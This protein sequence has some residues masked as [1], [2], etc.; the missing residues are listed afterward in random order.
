MQ[1]TSPPARLSLHHGLLGEPFSAGPTGAAVELAVTPGMSSGVTG[2]SAECMHVQ[3]ALRQLVS[4]V[5]RVHARI[6]EFASPILE[7]LDLNR[8]CELC[9]T[10][11]SPTISM[12]Q[13]TGH[14]ANNMFQHHSTQDGIPAQLGH[15]PDQA[16]AH[17]HNEVQDQAQA[18]DQGQAQ[19]QVQ[20]K[21]QA[22]AQD[23]GLVQAQDQG[24]VQAQDQGLVQ[25]QDQGLV[26]AQDQ[27]LVQAQ[28]QGLVQRNGV[29]QVQVPPRD[30]DDRQEHVNQ[31]EHVNRQEQVNQQEHV[32]QHLHVGQPDHVDPQEHVVGARDASRESNKR[33]ALPGTLTV[34]LFCCIMHCRED[35][36]REFLDMCGTF[37]VAVRAY[38]FCPTF[39]GSKNHAAWMRF[40]PT[41]SGKKN[42]G[43]PWCFYCGATLV[44]GRVRV[45]QTTTQ[46]AH[47][48]LLSLP[49]DKDVWDSMDGEASLVC[50]G[51]WDHAAHQRTITN[52]CSKTG[53]LPATC[54]G[55]RMYAAIES[56]AY[57]EAEAVMTATDPHDSAPARR[58]RPS[59]MSPVPIG[60]HRRHRAMSSGE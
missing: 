1:H 4:E 44:D 21:D 10:C 52:Y 19:D 7:D 22:Q 15:L 50:V 20:A 14:R 6:D 9:D 59:P 5:R 48:K 58:K 45:V 40:C 51:C 32:D 3:A 55:N 8:L 43:A 13:D 2:C 39:F 29:D 47:G 33:R 16:Q 34:R 57:D 12:A 53:L 60:I 37:G 28:D 56:L 18:Q 41:R 54:T 36:A 17:D 38:S 24:L 25:A 42:D 23:Q 27:G 11:P 26:Q 49:R 30:H 35:V 31:Q 46:V